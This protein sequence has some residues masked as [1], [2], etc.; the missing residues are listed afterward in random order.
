MCTVAGQE[1]MI[2]PSSSEEESDEEVHGHGHAPRHSHRDHE[3]RNSHRHHESRQE[4]HRHDDHSGG[5]EVPTS[6]AS[7][8]RCAAIALLEY[9]SHYCSFVVNV[10]KV[11]L[12]FVTVKLARCST[13]LTLTVSI[14]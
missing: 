2:D 5:L 1:A 11:G 4:H 14:V 7:L 9:Y 10:L 8:P 6:N 3:D 12:R 13:G